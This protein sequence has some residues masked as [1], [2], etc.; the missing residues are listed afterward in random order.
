MAR[1]IRQELY[2]AVDEDA[3]M[4]VNSTKIVITDIYFEDNQLYRIKGHLACIKIKIKPLGHLEKKIHMPAQI[5][6][7]GVRPSATPNAALAMT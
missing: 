7:N 4:A 3:F 5:S 6:S 2:S 1:N